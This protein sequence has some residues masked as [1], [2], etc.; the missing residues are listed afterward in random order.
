MFSRALLCCKRTMSARKAELR[1][2]LLVSKSSRY[3]LESLRHPGLCPR[4]LE[5]KLRRR[6]SDFDLLAHHHRVHKDFERL[7][8]AAMRGRGIETRLV[9]RFQLVQADVDWADFVFALG[10]DGTF[11]MVASSVT[12]RSKP[13]VGFNSDPARSEGHLCLPKAYSEDVGGAVDRLLQGRYRWMFRSRIRTTLLGGDHDKPPVE[14]Q[15]QALAPPAS[16]R[17]TEEEKERAT[18]TKHDTSR[19]LPFFALN[20]VFIGECLSAR[21]S[22][23]QLALDGGQST[24]VKS[25][26]LCVT[27]GT[28]STSWHLSMNRVDEQTVS[29]LAGLL[30]RRLSSEETRRVTS[31]YNASLVFSPE[32]ARLS[33]T[34]RDHICASVWPSPKG[35]EPRGFARHLL[36]TSHCFD[37]GL[38]IDG[39]LSFRFNDG[40]AARL[41]ICDCD[42]LRTVVLGD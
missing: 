15:G 29:R 26:G 32:D 23:Y 21:V 28:G 38:V 31:A 20:E 35:I 17:Y 36:V 11:L 3:E 2:A 6:G 13:V 27:T 18:R 22:Y 25:S 4:E 10:G 19:V 12:G 34:I 24:R 5:A 8:E 42:A 33:Y 30:G 16:E 37:A 1:R 40:N 39:R 7:V 9:N 14:L 41:E